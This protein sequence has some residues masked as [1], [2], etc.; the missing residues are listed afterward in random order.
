MQ[1]IKPP[2]NL[3][4]VRVNGVVPHSVFLA[5]SIEMG[6]AVDWQK[7]L[8]SMLSK[9]EGF[10]FN[11]RRDDWDS[12][13]EQTPENENFYGQVSWELLALE[14]SEVI[15]FYFDPETKSPIS[16]M[17]LG[18]HAASKKAIVCCPDGFWRKGNV[19]IVC[20]R[21]G[22]QVVN[23]LPELGAKILARLRV[24]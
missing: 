3:P 23:T 19:Q 14:I 12:T 20:E 15:A 1:V 7:N 2:E 18:L 16:L 6:K 4:I 10:I 17:E 5:G 22:I 21:Y 9:K 13:W 24:I 8:E 11:P